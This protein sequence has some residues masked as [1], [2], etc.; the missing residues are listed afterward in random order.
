MEQAL[1]LKRWT[2]TSLSCA[3][4]FS[5]TPRRPRRIIAVAKVLPPP[6]P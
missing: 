4:T 5:T 2:R 3:A 1:E 6:S